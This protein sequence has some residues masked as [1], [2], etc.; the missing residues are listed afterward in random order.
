MIDRFISWLY[1]RR[2]YGPRCSEYESSCIVCEQ[3]KH[4]DEMFGNEK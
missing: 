1:I 3:W 2:L 4:H